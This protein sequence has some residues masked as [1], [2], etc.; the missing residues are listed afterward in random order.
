[1]SVAPLNQTETAPIERRW[2]LAGYVLIGALLLAR[3]AYLACGF[4][5][6]TEDEAYQW[7]WSKHLALSYFSKP[8]MIAYTQFLGTTLWGDSEFGIR[9][10]SPLMSAALAAL[11]LRFLAR[12]VS[13]RAGFW[14]VLAV[15]AAPLP[16]VGSI[17]LTIDPLSVLFWTAAMICGWYAVQRDSTAL[18]VLTGFWM[19]LGFLSKY[20]GLFQFLS[21]AVFFALWPGARR[22]LRRPGPY[23]A[24]LIVALSTIPVL[25][26]NSQHHWITVTHIESRGGLDKSWVWKPKWTFEFFGQELGLLNPVLFIA[27]TW[28]AIAFWKRQ[29]SALTVFLFSMG[30]P[31]FIF[32]TL[33]TFRGRVQPNWI[34]PTIVP[35]FMLGAIYWNGRYDSVNR[36]MKNIFLIGIAVGLLV[37]IVAHDT[38]LIGKITGHPLPAKLDPL[39][40]AHGHPEMTQIVGTAR[41]HLLAEGKPVF[42]IGG[43]YGIASLITFYLPEAKAAAGKDSF[44]FVETSDKPKNQFYFWPG[45]TERRGQNALYVRYAE[46]PLPAHDSLRAQFETVTDLGIHEVNYDGTVLHCIQIYECRNLR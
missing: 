46:S 42:I 40:R 3:W 32:Y 26:W 37:V 9:F 45:Y 27:L 29:R 16:A 17:L 34:A 25:I 6:L 43:H 23:L 30:A 31:L 28:A 13:A 12:E 19:G 4:I 21:W 39:R 41:E 18:W 38:S 14:L 35:L 22:Q 2:L 5:G 36:A 7:L 24:L 11:G 20:T 8:P 1:M 44:V 33:Y 10:F 15:S